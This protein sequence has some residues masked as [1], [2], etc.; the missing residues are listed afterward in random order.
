MGRLRHTLQNRRLLITATT[1]V[2]QGRA[3]R[4]EDV[5]FEKEKIGNTE[6]AHFSKQKQHNPGVQ[7]LVL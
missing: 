2:G 6:H 1:E 3:K 5:A 7:Q 4:R